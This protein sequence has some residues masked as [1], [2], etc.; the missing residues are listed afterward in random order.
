MSASNA[1]ATPMTPARKAFVITPNDGADLAD[2]PKALYANSAGN[3]RVTMADGG[4]VTYTV[5]GPG[6]LDVCPVRV[7]A[8]GTTV[9]SLIGLLR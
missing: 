6:P 4:T 7:W 9:S 2:I 5:A 1:N 3:V 8:T